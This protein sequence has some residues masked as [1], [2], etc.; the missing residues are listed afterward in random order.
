MANNW[1][2]VI[3]INHY[4]HHP[5]RQLKYAVSDAQ[6]LY[7]FLCTHAGFAPE[8]TLLCLGNEEQRS[9]LNYPTYST[10]LRLLNRVLHPDRTG[11]VDRLWFF[12]AGHG[13][14]QNGRDYLLTADSLQEDIE[15]KIALPIDEVI[16][17]L[18]K[19]QT[20]DIVLILD[21]CRQQQGSRQFIADVGK[22][23]IELAQ[24]R[25]IT[26]I[27]S[28][29]YGQYSYELDSKKQGAFT[30]ALVEG[31]KQ[32]TLPDK[33]EP[34]L[35]RRVAELN[36]RSDQIPRIRVEPT[37]K[38]SQPLLPSAVTA[39]DITVLVDRAREAELEEDFEGAKQLW[40]QVIEVAQSGD[41]IREGRA[42][43]DRIDQKMARLRGDRF[44]LAPFQNPV[45]LK[46]QI[47]RELGFP[48]FDKIVELIK[49]RIESFSNKKIAYY[50]GVITTGVEERF[51]LKNREDFAC[52]EGFTFWFISRGL[53]QLDLFKQKRIIAH[54]RR[55]EFE[56]GDGTMLAVLDLII[57]AGGV[58][59]EHY[60][61]VGNSIVPSDE[62]WELLDRVFK[63]EELTVVR[64]SSVNKDDAN[65]EFDNTF[66]S[67]L[68]RTLTQIW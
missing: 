54:L 13:I 32:H 22:Q 51:E 27:F 10:L 67:R 26:T 28:C 6:L 24:S 52:G 9:S 68:L 4:D 57:A 46:E 11:Q 20:A 3:G 2:I 7:D 66:W 33:L 23:T 1:A 25:G 53:A 56:P 12:F 47:E 37:S 49:Q 8:Q 64:N 58:K 38:A 40:W 21:N 30:C 19:H 36:G 35:R 16:A 18:R 61:Q 50:V 62:G 63:C 34:Y 5:E 15:F 48:F 39:A 44:T 14:S 45:S 41:R 60:Y 59:G 65:P 43:I 42:A 17:S 29:D 55:Q 31:L